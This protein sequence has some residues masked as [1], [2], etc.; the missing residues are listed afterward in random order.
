MA[1]VADVLGARLKL[2]FTSAYSGG[3]WTGSVTTDRLGQAT[4]ANRPTIGTTPDG[5]TVLTFDGEDSLAA[6]GTSDNDR[7]NV[8]AAFPGRAN[9]QRLFACVFRTSGTEPGEYAILFYC[10]D[11]GIYLS[12]WSSAIRI[13]SNT[14]G[15]A[16]AESNGPVTD[17]QWHRLIL[18]ADDTSG[19]TTLY[20]D[21]VAQSS[22]LARVIGLPGDW[23]TT[24]SA[25]VGGSLIGSL[26]QLTFAH[27]TAGQTFSNGDIT[28]L[29]AA[30]QEFIA[31]G[32][33]EPESIT[34]T[35]TATL[36][37]ATA[38]STGRVNVRGS[39][40]TTLGAATTTSSGSTTVTGSASTPLGAATATATGAV[41]TTGALASGLGEALAVAAGTVLVVGSLTSTLGSATATASGRVAI[42]GTLSSQL[43]PATLVASDEVRRVWWPPEDPAHLF[44]SF[45]PPA[46]I[47]YS[48]LQD[49]A[50]IAS[51]DFE[52]YQ[53]DDAS[54]PLFFFSCRQVRSAAWSKRS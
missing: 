48:T 7:L 11:T 18:V 53:G 51:Y 37:A 1:S 22:T 19:V 26:G 10:G 4:A 44:A 52:V 45:N 40:A 13:D 15:Y 21:G 42:V 38:S 31:G 39:G 9:Y 14:E 43:D 3:T 47:L 12:P 36:G 17:D 41:R 30:L 24:W 54:V 25:T 29:D 32:G 49:M 5:N 6:G 8:L 46:V 20:I 33:E 2:Q 16:S 34:G 23:G 27:T 28:A 50:H 35:L